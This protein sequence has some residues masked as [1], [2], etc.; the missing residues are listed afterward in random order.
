MS[1]PAPWMVW[2]IERPAGGARIVPKKIRVR[3][4]IWCDDNG[5]A[6]RARE[7]VL[8]FVPKRRKKTR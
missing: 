3:C 2:L 7:G 6:P 5:K 1:K 8:T 4:R